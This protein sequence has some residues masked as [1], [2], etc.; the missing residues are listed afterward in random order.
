M[1]LLEVID[2]IEQLTE[3]PTFVFARN[4]SNEIEP[5]TRIG[6]RPRC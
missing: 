1:N 4:T 6:D 5:T 2:R 3:R